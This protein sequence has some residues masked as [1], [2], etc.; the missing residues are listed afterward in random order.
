MD[1][2]VVGAPSDI[3]F[4]VASF[5]ELFQGLPNQIDLLP[6]FGPGSCLQ[7]KNAD[8]AI[9]EV[10]LI[11]QVLVGS[12]QSLIVVCL[13]LIEEITVLELRPS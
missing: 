4:R 5:F 1:R 11:L 13:A 9:R 7:D 2:H 12:D 3:Y 10:L 6:D 8:G